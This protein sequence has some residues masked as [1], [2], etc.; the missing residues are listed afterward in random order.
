MWIPGHVGGRGDGAADG[1]VKEAL[2]GEPTA[3]LVSFFGPGALDCQIC[4]SGLAEEIGW[5]CFGVW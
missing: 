4:V 1:A 3:D 2:D 5:D